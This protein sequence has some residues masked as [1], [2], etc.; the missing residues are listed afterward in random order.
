MNLVR[1]MVTLSALVISAVFA[2]ACGGNASLS[3]VA[4]SSTS[5]GA[6]I[7]GTISGSALAG[8]L[9]TDTGSFTMLETRGVTVSV[10]GTGISTTADG[11]GRFT[12]ENVPS[13]TVQLNFT[14]PGSNATVTL[15]GIG[16][17]DRVQIAVTV[18][19]NRA[20]VDSEHH[21]N[22]EIDGRISSIDT[23]NKTFR[24]GDWTIKTTS[25]TVI[26]RE[27]RTTL[28]FTDLKVGDH[29]EVHGARDGTTVT[30][31]E[32]KVEQAGEDDDENDAREIE[33]EGVISG[34]DGTC[35]SVT[36]TVRNTKVKVDQNTQYRGTACGAASKNGVKVDVKGTRQSDGV[37][38]ATRVSLED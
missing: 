27:S 30:A 10:V 4:P 22:G 6:S 7:S 37:V 15:T 32:I 2:S 12:L 18:N 23:A 14:G 38:L 19:G 24:A 8:T 35:P 29:V 5:A 3:P 20:H 9:A 21:N 25:S 36:F 33:L 1:S 31:T 34:S 26:R 13:G 17:N 28:Q 11:Q 16:P